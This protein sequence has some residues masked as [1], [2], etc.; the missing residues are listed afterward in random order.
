[1]LR[2]TNPV[3]AASALLLLA[4]CEPA[5]TASQVT[6]ATGLYATEY[7]AAYAGS[8][9]RPP[10][11]PLAQLAAGER[12]IVVSDTYGK[13]YWACKVRTQESLSGWVLCTSLYERRSGGA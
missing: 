7:E 13:D 9:N 4:G 3:L 12:V 6:E 1:M 5:G 11:K 2:L 8:T 10:P